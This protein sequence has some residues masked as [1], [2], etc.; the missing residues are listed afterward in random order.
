MSRRIFIYFATEGEGRASLSRLGAKPCWNH[1]YYEF[2][3]GLIAIGGMGILAAVHA[4]SSTIHEVD[5]IWNFGIAG[6]LQNHFSIGE[7]VCISQVSRQNVGF[8]GF[9]LHAKQWHAELFPTIHLQGTGHRLVS[10]DYP[11]YHGPLRDQ[12]AQQADLVDMEGYGIA[13]AAAKYARPCVFWKI[14]SDF[15]CEGGP[16][17][18]LRQLDHY[19]EQLAD[20]VERSFACT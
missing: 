18:I 20:L 13:Y 12:L 3:R 9:D 19:S 8:E 16:E 5:E 11:I 1:P 2:S 14:V 7:A 17:L 4:I 15:A 10:C 6:S